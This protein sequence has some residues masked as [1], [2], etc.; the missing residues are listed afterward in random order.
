MKVNS[1][2]LF[3]AMAG[4][5]VNQTE[6]AKKAGISSRTMTAILSGSNCRPDVLGRISKA[7]N[8]EPQELVD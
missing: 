3:L 4:A 6:L 5:N 2:K 7:L 8:V 1:K